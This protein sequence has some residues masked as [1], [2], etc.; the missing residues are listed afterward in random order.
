MVDYRKLRP[1]NITSPEFRHLLLLLYWPIYGLTFLIL[2]R[3]LT[4]D[5]HPVEA[6]LDAKI[7]FCEYFVP[8]YYFWFI[9]LI[10]IHFYTGFFDV[11]A[12]KKLMYFIIITYTVTSVIYIIYPTKQELRPAEFSGDNIFIAIINGLYNFDTNTNVCPSLHVIGSF[13]VLFTS[14]HCKRFKTFWWQFGFVSATVLIC[15]ST[16]FLKQHSV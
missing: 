7:P 10:G 6:A 11:P 16:V 5:Y 8:A 15:L 12:F 3:G 13:A 14:W 2:E 9:F 1:S 4:L